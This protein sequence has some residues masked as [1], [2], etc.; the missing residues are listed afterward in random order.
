LAEMARRQYGNRVRVAARSTNHSIGEALNGLMDNLRQRFFFILAPGTRPTPGWLLELMQVA[1][2]EGML[3]GP[4]LPM[5]I[6]YGAQAVAVPGRASRREFRRAATRQRFEAQ[7][8]EIV[9]ALF[10]TCI[11]LPRNTLNQIGHFDTRYESLTGVLLDYQNRIR[12]KGGELILACRA[13]L[14]VPYAT[15][16]PEADQEALARRD[17]YYDA[18]RNDCPPVALEF[19]ANDAEHR[20]L[21]LLADGLIERGVPLCTFSRG[22]P[23]LDR[24]AHATHIHAVTLEEATRGCALTLLRNQDNMPLNALRLE[25][26]D[27]LETNVGRSK[28]LCLDKEKHRISTL[29]EHLDTWAMQVRAAARAM[30]GA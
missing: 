7:R 10:P 30:A 12:S 1:E 13:L 4:C 18:L 9:D 5:G 16:L 23:V 6:V 2:R 3:V 17:R 26:G 22:D 29:S 21:R 24:P 19:E 20:R 25:F 27:G 8:H 14:A 11:G 28:T 15:S